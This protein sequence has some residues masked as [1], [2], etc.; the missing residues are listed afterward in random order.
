M[1]A[2]LFKAFLIH[3]DFST[4]IIAC[5]FVPLLKGA[6]KDSSKSDN[7]R[8]I[9]ISSLILKVFDN[10]IIILFGT[11]LATDWLQFGFKPKTGTTQC[12]WFVLEVVSY[13]WQ[14]NTSVKSALLDC[15]KA[16][17]KCLF[18]VLFGKVLSR[19][20]PA[21]FVRVLLSIY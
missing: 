17:D 3:N 11:S 15:S 6:L 10:M 7:Y 19:G 13:F 12:S 9:A 5:A 14:H 1:I 20:V 18:S 2:E 4:D 8:A 16:F 21:I